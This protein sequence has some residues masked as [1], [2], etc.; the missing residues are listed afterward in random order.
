VLFLSRA[1]CWPIG[2]RPPARPRVR[3][4]TEEHIALA[5]AGRLW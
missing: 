2:S 3:S 5:V 1:P 4:D